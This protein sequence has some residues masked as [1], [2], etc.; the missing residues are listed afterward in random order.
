MIS[1]IL[2]ISHYISDSAPR[3]E[4]PSQPYSDLTSSA[5]CCHRHQYLAQGLASL[6][7]DAKGIAIRNAKRHGS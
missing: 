7:C 1:S 6:A 4:S 3:P 2:A 5:P